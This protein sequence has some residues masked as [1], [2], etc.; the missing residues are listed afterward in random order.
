MTKQVGQW[1][2]WIGIIVAV[3][4]YFLSA[5]WCLALGIVALVLGVIGVFSEEKT[6]NIITIILGAVGIILYFFKQEQK[7][8][9]SDLY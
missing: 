4:G 5:N 7:I 3:V 9:Q 1:L 2:G 6:L 8:K